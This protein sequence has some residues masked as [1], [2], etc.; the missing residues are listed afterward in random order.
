M[1]KLLITGASGFLG[2]QIG[3][4]AQ[5][6]W[7]LIGTY[8][9][10]PKSLTSNTAP[11]QIDLCKKDAI[12]KMIKETKPDAVFHLAA[13]SKT[14]DCEKHPE[15]ARNIN[16]QATQNLAEMCAEKKVKFIFTSSE[17]V[18]DGIE[19]NYKESD[20]PNPKNEYG[21]QK[22]E[23]EE[24]I[25]SLGIEAAIVRIAV[26][27]GKGPPQSDSFLEQWVS[28][29]EKHVPVNTFYDEVR[30]FLSGKSA[31]AGLLH[32]LEQDASGVFHLS[33]QEAVSRTEFAK[34]ATHI[35]DLPKAKINSISQ[36][37]VNL[38]T[39]RPKNLSL[40]CS[41]IEGTGFHLSS[42]GSELEQL[43]GA[44]NSKSNSILN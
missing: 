2:W 40:D 8:H 9:N 30:S 18:F 5:N 19:K 39:F 17:Q 42:L 1:K 41:K 29:W 32:L 4:A 11:Y 26:L 10:S 16:V 24:F 21:K 28:S 22:L 34:M 31:A 36:E 38:S 14:G 20:K 3:Q 43:K 25:Q 37:E 7:N 27:F 15:S 35:F 13:N 23:A 12:W 44:F 33:G 6:Q